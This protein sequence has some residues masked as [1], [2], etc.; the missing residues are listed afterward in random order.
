MRS[1]SVFTRTVHSFT[2]T[3]RSMAWCPIASK[4]IHSMI[5]KWCMSG[6]KCILMSPVL[7]HR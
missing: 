4:R 1:S 2:F 5:K 3:L 6:A 7:P